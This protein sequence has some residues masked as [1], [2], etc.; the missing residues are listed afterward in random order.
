M[1]D[2]LNSLRLYKQKKQQLHSKGR[3]PN[4]VHVQQHLGQLMWDLCGFWVGLWNLG[5]EKG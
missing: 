1:C 2:E 5:D 4:I 3:G